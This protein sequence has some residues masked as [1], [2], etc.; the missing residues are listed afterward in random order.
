MPTK[1][2]LEVPL[3]QKE[4]IGTKHGLEDLENCAYIGPQDIEQIR[5]GLANDGDPLVFEIM[6][7]Y[8]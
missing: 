7:E 2:H 8:E 6:N 4:V 1:V 3:V 5:I